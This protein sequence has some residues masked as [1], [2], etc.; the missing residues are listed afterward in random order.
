MQKY[1]LKFLNLLGVAAVGLLLAGGV[2]AGDLTQSQSV[3][4][5][6]VYYG[7]VPVSRLQQ[8]PKGSDE[9]RAHR[10]LPA[11]RNMYHL[12]VA[13]FK[14]DGMAR[15]SDAT[16]YARVSEPGLSADRKRLEPTTLN[17]ATAYCNYFAIHE[18]ARYTIDIDVPDRHNGEVVT[19]HFI[20]D[21][22]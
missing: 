3:G 14:T 22:T 16:V 19:A 1:S 6:T 2:A 18:G 21:D 8:F 5:Y 10:K 7:L 11:G 20:H 13:L 9:A 15:V 4:A 12:V 17:H